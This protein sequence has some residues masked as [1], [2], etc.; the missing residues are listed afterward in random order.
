VILIVKSKAILDEIGALP[1]I[2]GEGPPVLIGEP[3]VEGCANPRYAISHPFS[4]A[5]C[6]W[7][8][9]YTSGESPAGI[10]CEVLPANWVYLTS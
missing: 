3:A 9:A 1:V 8:Q 7:L 5:Q 4:E 2:E 6:D 10:L